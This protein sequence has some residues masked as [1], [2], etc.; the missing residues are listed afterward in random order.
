MMGSAL[1]F[2]DRYAVAGESGDEAADPLL[3][4]SFLA[5]TCC[6]WTAI[7]VNANTASKPRHGMTRTIVGS[8]EKFGK[9]GRQS[10][11]M[12]RKRK[13]QQINMHNVDE[14]SAAAAVAAAVAAAANERRQELLVGS[15][16]FFSSVFCVF[17]LCFLIFFLCFCLIDAFIVVCVTVFFFG[18]EDD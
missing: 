14:A 17:F 10:I 8:N 1:S 2:A 4:K 18:T 13:F 16:F 15:V 11:R 7:T 6:S 3:G 9:R 12:E 5:V